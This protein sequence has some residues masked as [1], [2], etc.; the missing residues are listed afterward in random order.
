MA[1][2]P[3]AG[4]Q[5]LLL[6]RHQQHRR[7]GGGGGDTQ[8][9]TTPANL[10]VT[11]T[12]SSS[13]ALSWTAST[14]NVGVNGYDVYRGGT[15]VGTATGT[16]YTDTGL[17]A[18]TAYSYTVKAV[19]AAGNLSAASNS[20][21]ATTQAGSGGG[22]G[23]SASLAVTSQWNPGFTD[24]VTVS[25]RGAGAIHGWTVTWTWPGGQQETSAW[26]AAVSQSG[27][28]VTATNLSYN[29][30]IAAGGTT[31][32]GLQGTWSGSNGTPTLSCTAN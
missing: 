24:T 21:T 3:R 14:D 18:S 7:R 23:C 26:N 12:T 2:R 19:D 1:G 31:T 6:Q 4:H 27:S 11:G 16:G 15:L 32:F 29:G 25:N 17:S 10:T 9:P 5:Q 20:A 28:A 22:S 30:A 8:A 13:A